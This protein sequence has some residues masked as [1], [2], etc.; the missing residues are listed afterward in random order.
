M[1]KVIGVPEHPFKV[2]VTT[3]VPVVIVKIVSGVRKGVIFPVPE[4]P[5]PIFVFEFTQL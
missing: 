3:I 2:G 1:L 4:A 5:K